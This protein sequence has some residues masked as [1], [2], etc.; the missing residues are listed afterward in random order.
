MIEFTFVVW[1][2]LRE[3]QS[4]FASFCNTEMSQDTEILSRGKQ[5]PDSP[6]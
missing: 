1:I 2:Y 6:E 4:V 3:Y 5:K